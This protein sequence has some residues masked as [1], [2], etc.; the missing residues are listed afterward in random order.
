M[1]NE[2]YK[3]HPATTIITA[4][5]SLKDLMIPL[6]ILIV[7]NGFQF[8]F[9]IRSETFFKD[10]FSIIIFSVI[11]LWLFVSG[12]VK[13]LTFSY[14]FEDNELRIE[15]GLI[16]KK[17]RYIPFERIQNLNYKE[18]VLHRLFGLVQVFVETA[19]STNGKVEAELTAITRIAADQIEQEMKK[20]K[21]QD[22]P[23]MNVEQLSLQ[24]IHKM[25]V[26]DLLIVA[27]TSNS[28]GVVLLGA[29]ALI[30]QLAEFIPFDA[31]F[32]ELASLIRFSF[33]IITL[34]IVIMLLVVWLVS[35]AITAFNYA[36]FTVSKDNERLV[37]TRGLLEKKRVTL[38]IK[39]VQA[40]KIVENPIRQLFGL[41]TVVVES[42]GGNFSGEK[43]KK[44]VLLPILS[45][46]HLQPLLQQLFPTYEFQF[47][48]P[49][50]SP[51]RARPFFYRMNFFYIVPIIIGL[52]Y[53]FYPYGLLSLCIIVLPIILGIWKH[54]TAAFVVYDHQ[55]TIRYR[56]ISRVTFFAPKNRIQMLEQRQTYFQ[57]RQ[58][59]ATAN[60][61][62]MSGED[63]E[64]A[65]VFHMG[66]KDIERLLS[67]YEG[68]I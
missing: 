7:A 19:G 62:V 37:I 21:Q 63:G 61:V 39:R 43:D 27:A 32:A 28:V 30:S 9:D 4:F 16:V 25:S 44:I 5:K 26:R 10:S 15:Y 13:W 56:T 45:K 42:A 49:T 48:Q 68:K 55:L 52:S 31:I 46:K 59:I 47:E 20:A 34:L 60:I 8:N 14:W 51:K 18:S 12:I 1:F 17:K 36:Q 54:R 66:E 33:V 29:F 24:T 35:V 53:F 11:F 50:I 6:V 41:C 40:I 23:Y 64:S 58:H 67:W 38:P 3:L 22:V 2:K 57:K 65:K